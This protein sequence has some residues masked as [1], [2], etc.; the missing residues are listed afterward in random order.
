MA[1]YGLG[2]DI[3]ILP[4]LD[5]DEIL[6]SE[7]D[8]LAQ[9][10]LIRL[11]TPRG[12]L[13]DGTEEGAEFGL[14]VKAWLNESLTPQRLLELVV[15]A[16]L[17]VLK[18]DRVDTCSASRSTF[19]SVTRTLNLRLDVGTAAGPHQFSI[20]ATAANLTLLEAS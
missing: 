11:S 20:Y 9:D 5:E 17:E 7:L 6:V 19:D 15:N 18:D 2:V 13:Q 16:E 12:A 8:C 10:I 3:K 1:E 14:D 4:D